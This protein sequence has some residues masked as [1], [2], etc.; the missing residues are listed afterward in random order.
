MTSSKTWL[1][2]SSEAEYTVKLSQNPSP[3][4]SYMLTKNKFW[5]KKKKKKKNFVAFCCDSYYF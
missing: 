3:T 5:K 2:V 1:K 4:L